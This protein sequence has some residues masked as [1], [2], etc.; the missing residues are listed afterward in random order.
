MSKG[1]P[2]VPIRFPVEL[3]A[4]VDREVAR[5]AGTRAGGLRTRSSF[6]LAAVRTFLN[7]RE[8][9]RQNGGRKKGK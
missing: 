6:V 3:L 8:R 4:R 9:S 7:K 5:A 2:I 1:S